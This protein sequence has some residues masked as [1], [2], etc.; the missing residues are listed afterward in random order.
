MLY[1]MS[2]AGIGT[3][4][5]I[6][7]LSKGI[8]RTKKVD[9]VEMPNSNVEDIVLG[10][11]F[12]FPGLHVSELTP[13]F[14]SKFGLSFSSKGLIVLDPGRIAVRL[15]LR[16]GDLLQEINGKSVETIE[17]AISAIGSIKSNGSIT[18]SRSGRRIALRFRL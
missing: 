2:V 1:R 5:D 16:S 13:E 6:S 9:L 12:I 10:P 17:D 11:K 7:Y 14:Q 18:I 3:K 15:G 4:V 8:T